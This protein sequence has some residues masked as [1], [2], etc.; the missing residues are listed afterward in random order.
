MLIDRLRGYFLTQ[1]GEPRGKTFAG[2][3]FNAAHC[4]TD[5]AW[6]RASADG[7]ARWRRPIAEAIRAFRRDLNVLVSRGVWRMFAVALRPVSADARRRTRCS[8]FPASSSAPSTLLREMDEFAQSRYRLEARY[9]HVLV[10]E[11]QDTSRAQWELVVAA[12]A[13]AGAKGSALPPT[14]CLRRSSSSATA[15]SRSTAFATPTCRSSTMRRRSSTALRPEGDARRAI[16]VSFRAVP[17]LLAFVND[18]VRGDR[19]KARRTGAMTVSATSETDRFP[20]D[21]D[22]PADRRTSRAR[23]RRRPIRRSR[24]RRNDVAAEIARLLGGDASSAIARPACARAAK[25]A[26][27]AIL[28]RSR[29]SHREFEAALERRGISTYVYKGLGFFDADEIQDVLALLRYLAD[30][31]SDLRAAAL[32]A[33]AV[34][35]AVGRWR[36]AARRRTLPTRILARRAAPRRRRLSAT[37]IAACSRRCAR[38]CARWLSLVD[39]M[40]PAELLDRVLDET[41]MSS[42]SRGRGRLQARENLKK[43]RGDDPAHP[44]PRLRDAGA[45]RGA[46]R[47]AGRR[48]RVERGDRRASMPSA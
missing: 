34:R 4:D 25:P 14:R 27:I 13:G 23:R 47:S 40:T 33:L 31:L 10:D 9:H 12:R 21:V 8:I 29:D 3:G 2:T 11:F 36:C 41:A 22:G 44:E 46:S 30:P 16:S 37:K 43:L 5:D 48:R 20:V 17:A 26:D 6:K 15:S 18:V 35:A 39:R 38:P 1:D 32:P 7:V 28:F 45:H 42:R 24:C 19:T